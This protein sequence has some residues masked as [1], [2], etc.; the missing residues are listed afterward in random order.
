MKRRGVFMKKTANLC[1]SHLISSDQSMP[2]SRQTQI[3]SRESSCCAQN[4]FLVSTS[5]Q[6]VSRLEFLKQ[7]PQ[8][9]YTAHRSNFRLFRYIN[10][11]EYSIETKRGG[12]FC[13][14]AQCLCIVCGSQIAVPLFL[15]PS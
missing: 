14:V 15:I 1:P 2:M 11:T 4:Y 10:M 9:N 3:N 8:L 13:I 5:I 12:S 7:W 6:L